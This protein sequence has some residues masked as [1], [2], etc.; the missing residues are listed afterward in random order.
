[1]PE[2]TISAHGPYEDLGIAVVGLVRDIAATIPKDVSADLWRMYLE[3]L[4]EWRAF[5]RELTAK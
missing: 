2:P 1:V 5:L 4:K 3:D